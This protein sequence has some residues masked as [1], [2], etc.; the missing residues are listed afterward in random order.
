MWEWTVRP[1]RGLSCS[2]LV[3]VVCAACAPTPGRFASR[4]A[5]H[6][7]HQVTYEKTTEWED[8]INEAHV[9]KTAGLDTPARRLQY[10]RLLDDACERG[11]ES[12]ACIEA[13]VAAPGSARSLLFH[14]C[15]LGDASAC[16]AL[17]RILTT[18]KTSPEEAR[19]EADRA[20]ALGCATYS[21]NACDIRDDL[22]G[23][24]ARASVVVFGDTDAYME[25][26][27]RAQRLLQAWRG[28][29]DACPMLKDECRQSCMENARTSCQ[30][31]TPHFCDEIK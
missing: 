16:Q 17:V 4:D 10:F 1:G 22:D 29:R 28:C 3:L 20:L 14:G 11:H 12:S 18:G 21:S 31:Q 19:A 27:Q 8:V 7:D 9:L 25:E 6:R 24:L 2:L 5:A 13:A 23:A 30:A 26:A 15:A